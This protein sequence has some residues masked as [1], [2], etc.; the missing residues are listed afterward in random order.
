[1]ALQYYLLG[2]KRKTIRNIAR[3]NY[4]LH[5]NDKEKAIEA[6][7]DELR[8]SS[9]IAAILI[10]VAIKLIIELIS[11]WIKNSVTI[12]EEEFIVGEPGYE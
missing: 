9:I 3:S 10:G 11:Y 2:N 1:M 4:L 5:K 12:P 7:I 6:A 8:T